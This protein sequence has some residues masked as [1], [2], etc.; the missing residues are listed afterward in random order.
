[1]PAYVVAL[2]AARNRVVIGDKEDLMKQSLLVRDLNITKYADIT[3]GMVV[4]CRIR[5][6]SQ[7]VT[8]RLYREDEAV[9]VEFDAPVESV[10]PGQSAVFYEG[11]DVVGGGIIC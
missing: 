10:T 8:A 9:R 11:D 3:D 4:D 1:M 6:R 7:G 5:Y 2:D